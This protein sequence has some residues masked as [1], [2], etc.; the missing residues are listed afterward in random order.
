VYQN[1]Q[2]QSD[3]I[4]LRHRFKIN[5][6]DSLVTITCGQERSEVKINSYFLGKS[7]DVATYHG[8]CTTFEYF[9]RVRAV[10]PCYFE[11]SNGWIYFYCLSVDPVSITAFEILAE[12]K[13]D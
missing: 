3:T 10:F 5:L 1:S 4:T 12:S 6:A 13:T 11:V 9:G 2:G 8:Y 7:P